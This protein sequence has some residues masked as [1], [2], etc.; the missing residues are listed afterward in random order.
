MRKPWKRG[1]LGMNPI[2]SAIEVDTHA[3]YAQDQMLK[4]EL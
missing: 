2:S 1:L 3:G 4:E